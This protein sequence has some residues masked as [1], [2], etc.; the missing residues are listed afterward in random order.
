MHAIYGTLFAAVREPG[1]HHI[2]TTVTED[3][4]AQKGRE[5][6]MEEL[7][8]TAGLLFEYIK[9]PIGY[10]LPDGT[11]VNDGDKSV[12][13]RAP[14]REDTGYKSLSVVG[15]G[16]E[17]LQNIELARGLDAISKETGWTAETAGALFDG[18]TVFLTLKCGQKSI[19][20]DKIDQYFIV[21]DGKG[22]GRGL[23]IDVAPVRVVCQ[24]TLMAAEGQ[25]VQTVKIAHNASV[26]DN[27]AFWTGF[28]TQLQSAQ[29][30]TFE[31]LKN[32]AT[33]KISDEQA[34]SIFEYAIEMPK[35]NPRMKMHETI[36][37]IEGLDAA[38]RETALAKM[39]S[40]I[41]HFE[42]WTD[43]TNKRRE[44]CFELY[45]RFNA[46]DEEGAKQG[47]PMSKKT[48]AAVSNTPYAAYNAV[49][50]LADWSGTQNVKVIVSSALFG[51]RATMK[52]RA[53]T[54]SEKLIG[55]D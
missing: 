18:G 24:N 51:D 55:V 45:Q 36:S 44:S 7:A 14:N 33:L 27:F 52:T 46:G 40:G 28:I 16:Y 30:D 9:T 19:F 20:G 37:Q 13:L 21:S 17:F 47:R 10:T 39:Q 23:K 15:S 41:D 12:I 8:D 1:W 3:M 34:K 43:V 22:T 2:G 26:R 11:F 32:L 53:F 31:R 29:D 49:S 42:F 38:S 6:T 25:A 48:L 50:E 4:I 54:A 5:F 35:K